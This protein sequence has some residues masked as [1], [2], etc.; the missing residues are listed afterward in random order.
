[1]CFKCFVCILYVS[2]CVLLVYCG[3]LSVLNVLRVFGCVWVFCGYI[4]VLW[5]VLSVFWVF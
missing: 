1:M 4:D 2:E 3:V 5:S